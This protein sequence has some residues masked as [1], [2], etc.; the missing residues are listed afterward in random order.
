MPGNPL[1]PDD[2]GRAG[3]RMSLTIRFLAAG[4]PWR[5]LAWDQRLPKMYPV[6]VTHRRIG[7]ASLDSLQ[8]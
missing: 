6:T 1:E 2:R 5:C 8:L 4:P 3:G 7:L